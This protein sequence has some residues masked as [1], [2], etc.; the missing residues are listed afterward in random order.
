MR[1][2]LPRLPK[3]GD[4]VLGAG[5]DCAAVA[6]RD[7]ALL[8]A[9]VD[10]VIGRV[11]YYPETPP[12]KVGEKLLKRNLSDIAAMGG[13][14]RWALLA[15]AV[16]G[17]DE[18]WILA[19]AEGILRYANTCG[20]AL[21]GGDLAGLPEDAAEEVA[22][23]TILGEVPP[24]EM[25]RRSG[26]IPGDGVYVTGSLGNSLASGHHLTFTPRLAEGRFLASRAFARAMMDISDGL[27]LDAS[28]LGKASGV[29]IVLE[30]DR[31]PLRSGADV[32]TALGDG[33]D[34]ELLFGVAPEKEAELERVWPTEFAPIRRIGRV[35]ATA[36][37]AVFDADGND[38]E[39]VG[40]EH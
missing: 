21:I 23:L 30:L 22:S 7:D 24:C 8:L 1:Q 9:A 38:L 6:W 11:H 35:A 3:G 15:C 2:L 19:L 33:E 25:V 40:Y 16:S 37:G 17:R 18:A 13:T 36:P 14:P 20:V 12:E 29:A 5:D 39:G 34:Y 26:L 28:R 31:L 4:I 10:Q 32:P 27:A